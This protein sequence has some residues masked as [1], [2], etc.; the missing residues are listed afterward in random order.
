MKFSIYFSTKAEKQIKKLPQKIKKRIK[1]ACLEICEN[2]WHRG[3]LKVEGYSNLR[4][5]RI[6]KYRIL[7]FIDKKR[8]EVLVVKVELRDKEVYKVGL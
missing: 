1:K 5:K 2:P 4:R 8:K 3:T 7:F 6:G